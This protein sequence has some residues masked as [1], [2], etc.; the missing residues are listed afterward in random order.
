MKGVNTCHVPKGIRRRAQDFKRNEPSGTPLT[1]PQN[2]SWRG[3]TLVAHG[4]GSLTQK[5]RH[6]QL[7]EQRASP[8]VASG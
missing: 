3:L 7:R 8:I 6:P 4:V 1:R 5:A 2:S